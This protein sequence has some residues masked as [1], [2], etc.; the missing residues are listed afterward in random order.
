MGDEYIRTYA[1]HGCPDISCSAYRILM[2]MAAAVYDVE[3][4]PGRDDEGLYY[5]GWKSL[6]AVLGYG[7]TDDDEDIPADAKRT[8]TRAMRELRTKGYLD[9]ADK[10]KQREH[11]NRVYRLSLTAWDL[12]WDLHT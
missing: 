4:E 9:V 6:T 7:V 11:W 1:A 10:R 12:T 5:G 2:R 8:I 3:S